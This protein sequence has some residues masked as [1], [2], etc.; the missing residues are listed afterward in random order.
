MVI[1]L[2]VSFPGSQ[3]QKENMISYKIIFAHKI[4]ALELLK[5]VAPVRFERHFS[6]GTE[7]VKNVVLNN[8]ISL[9][10]TGQ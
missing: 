10:K 2:G 9:Q 8:K 7:H 3:N 1:E 4:K 5:F 6:S